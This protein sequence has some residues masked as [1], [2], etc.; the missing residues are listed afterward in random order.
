MRRLA[1]VALAV[2]ACSKSSPPTPPPPPPA[3]APPAAPTAPPNCLRDVG[4]IQA[5]RGAPAEPKRP[6]HTFSIVARDPVTGDLGVAVQS[7]WFAVGAG[8]TWAEPG[9]GAIATQSFAEPAYGRKGLERM[10]AGT[11]APDALAAL[12]AE[13]AKR[14]VRQVA[15]VDGKGQVAAHTGAANIAFAGHHTGAGY[16]VQANMM[17][18]DRVVPAMQAAYEGATGDLAERLLATLA[19]AQAAG[20]DVRGCQSAAMLIVKGTPSAEPSHDTLVDLRVDDA[21]DPIAE[22]GRLLKLQRVYD[23]MNAG[24]AAVERGD[25]A[26]AKQH[27][28]A[29]AAAAPTLTEVRYWS[30]VSLAVAGDVDAALPMFTTIFTEDSRWIELTRRIQPAVVP[31]TPEGDAVI[32]KILTAAPAPR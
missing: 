23:H 22:L 9:V 6:T 8:V 5:A 13:D 30:A 19:A 4:Q 32:Q 12:L 15:F 3:P 18:N 11:S 26:G 1:V 7:H 21:A 24:D 27:Y 29:A 28:G 10:R 16:S 14:D 25:V 17:A 20:G 2:V 31:A